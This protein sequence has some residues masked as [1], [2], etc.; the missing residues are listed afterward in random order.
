MPTQPNPS[1]VGSSFMQK[2]YSNSGNLN[3]KDESSGSRFAINYLGGSE[4]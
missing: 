3:S 2:R 4:E 1:Q